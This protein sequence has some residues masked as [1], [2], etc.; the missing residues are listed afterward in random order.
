[1][2][3]PFR[4]SGFRALGFRVQGSRFSVSGLMVQCG[5][6]G[7]IFAALK[8]EDVVTKAIMF[9]SSSNTVAVAYS[10]MRCNVIFRYRQAGGV[11]GHL[12]CSQANQDYGDPKP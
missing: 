7:T 9:P 8:L 11:T 10:G 3:R 6:W 2:A 5:A 12:P 1:M 4:V